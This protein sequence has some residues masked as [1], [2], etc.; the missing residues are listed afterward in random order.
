MFQKLYKRL[1]PS[2]CVLCDGHTRTTQDLCS[3][4]KLNLP[5]NEPC[6]EVCAQPLPSINP[7][8]FRDQRWLHGNQVNVT[9]VMEAPPPDEVN[10]SANRFRCGECLSKASPIA[11]STIPYLY[12][13][14]ADFMIRRLKYADDIKYGRLIG[15][16]LCDA[17]LKRS[18]TLPDCL[19]PVPLHNE[20]YRQ[21]GFNQA[22]MI[23]TELSARLG[24]PLDTSSA[25]RVVAGA[26]QAALGAQ[27]RRQN[28]RRAFS[29][30][31][32][33]AGKSV[34]IVDDVYT[35]GATCSAL[36]RELRSAGA[37]R[38]EVWAFARTP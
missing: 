32:V 25:T 28:M 7:D 35:T 18:A 30:K 9:E 6:C 3:D 26:R 12:R 8:Y 1:L 16:L 36:A 22:Q 31:E 15:E 4:C 29:V 20:R 23:A 27:D 11:A 10:P 24:L 37:R 2:V 38:V 17:V 34:A 5:V 14:P 21:R 13:P 19:L 33:V